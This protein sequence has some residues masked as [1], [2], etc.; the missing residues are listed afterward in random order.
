MYFVTSKSTYK[1]LFYN[2]VNVLCFI[3]ALLVLNNEDILP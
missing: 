3:T 1:Q 2:N